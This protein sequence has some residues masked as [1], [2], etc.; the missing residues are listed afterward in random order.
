VD[1]TISA[2]TPLFS[3]RPLIGGTYS[4]WSP[5]DPPALW[6]RVEEQDD[7]V[8]FGVPVPDLTDE[9]LLAYCRRLNITALV[10]TSDDF[11]TRTLLD[12]SPHFQSYYNN[13]LYFV[14][15]RLGGTD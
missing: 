15:Q 12:A 9:Q 11:Q 2:L 3:K 7:Q 13:G 4:H 1:T 14:Y 6:G 5:P 10:A 8:L